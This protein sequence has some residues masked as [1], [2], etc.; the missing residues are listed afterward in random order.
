MFS[1]LRDIFRKIS[2]SEV[3]PVLSRPRALGGYFRWGRE[4]RARPL[5]MRSTPPSIEIELTNRCNLACIQC[6]RSQGLKPY[7]LGDIS[8]DDYKR[9]LAQFPDAAVV[10]LN[11]F[12]EPLLHPRFF[13]IVGWTRSQLPGAKIVIY[14]NGMLLDA[15]T[16]A[17]AI[18]GGLSE[19]NVS[20][21]AATPATYRRVRRGGELE[22]VHANLRTLLAAR[23]ERRS[24]FPLVG[25]NY[26]MVNEN[27]GE[28]VP[29]IEQAHEIGVD[30]VNCISYATY[31]WG[32][33]NRRS[34]DSYRRELSAARRRLD[35]LGLRCRSFPSDD[36][37]WTDPAKPFDCP[38]FWGSSVRITFQGEVTLGC[39]TP[40]AE[41][42]SYGNVLQ[43]P[44]SEIW[45]GARFRS[46]RAATLAQRPPA[47]A[48]ESC[49]RT[50]KAFFAAES[51]AIGGD[52]IRLRTLT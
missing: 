29:F 48:C 6:L 32:F 42:Y 43:R 22:V 14:S 9:I 10:C 36:L 18:G 33:V 16:A 2:E 25:V 12:G 37:S 5:V 19:V 34:R 27:E 13:E 30:F 49:D 7:E 23:R 51:T 39:C 17:R 38:F 52:G 46:N 47:A 44:F 8:F 24:R 20:I 35:E 3:L 26:V 50:C 21:D 11:G 28:L 4:M 45:N 1:R 31:D 15:K 41:T 40:F